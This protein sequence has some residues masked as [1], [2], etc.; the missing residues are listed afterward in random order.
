MNKYKLIG[1]WNM[2]DIIP[3]FV[4]PVFEKENVLYLQELSEDLSL[5]YIRLRQDI[6]D[7][8]LRWEKF[9]GDQTLKEERIIE[10]EPLYA[11][12]NSEEEIVCGIDKTLYDY[13]IRYDTHDSILKEEIEDFFIAFK[14]RRKKDPQGKKDEVDKP[15]MK[16]IEARIGRR[17][18]NV[19]KSGAKRRRAILASYKNKSTILPGGGKVIKLDKN[20]KT[21]PSFVVYQKS[22]KRGLH[23]EISEPDEE[24]I[25]KVMDTINKKSG[26]L[27]VHKSKAGNKPVINKKKRKRETVDN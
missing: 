8:V 24:N 14:N 18:L 17:L 11:F 22:A 13:L 21:T 6:Y 16:N 26:V 3:D 25:K 1:F 5:R 4:Y 7:F 27:Q 19:D 12:Q 23:I 9:D 2:F 15:K 10:S 20:G